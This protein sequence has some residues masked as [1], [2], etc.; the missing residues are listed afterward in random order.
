MLDPNR[1]VYM[2]L[3]LDMEVSIFSSPLCLYLTHVR[4]RIRE[5]QTKLRFINIFGNL[6]RQRLLSTT[7]RRICSSVRNSF[8]ELVS[9][10]ILETDS[11]IEI[12]AA[13]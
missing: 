7:I 5:K 9:P 8:W 6:S 11:I 4:D 10:S 3:N 1:V 12:V 13:A 2:K